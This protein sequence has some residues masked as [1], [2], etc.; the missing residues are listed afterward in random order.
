MTNVHLASSLSRKTLSFALNVLPALLYAAT[1]F[2]GGLI[3]MGALPQV[4]FVATDKLLH[5]SAF[6]GLALLLARA[7]HWFWPAAP[8]RSL[9]FRGAFGASAAGL[10]LELC[11]AFTS[12]R[13]ADAWDWIA[14]TIGAL[15]VV[16]V[17]CAVLKWV[18]RRAH[19]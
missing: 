15:L 3:R 2:Y 6:A 7:S 14:D 8:S 11:Q 18:P 16:A 4:G 17:G 12:Y 1:I 5:A 19:G 10:L 9:L 13:S